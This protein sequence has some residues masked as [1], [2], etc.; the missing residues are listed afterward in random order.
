MGR[1]LE[2]AGRVD[3]IA[4]KQKR[5]C[6]CWSGVGRSAGLAGRVGGHRGQ[7]R[8]ASRAWMAGMVGLIGEHGGQDWQA[9]WAGSGGTAGRVCRLGGSGRGA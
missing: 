7:D 9:W 2:E 6:P 1:K 4:A 8:L 5:T 3:G